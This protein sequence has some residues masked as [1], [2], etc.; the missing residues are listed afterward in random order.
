M[1]FLNPFNYGFLF[2]YMLFAYLI[3]IGEF[4]KNIAKPISLTLLVFSICYGIFYSFDLTLGSQFILIYALLPYSF[5]VAGR[6]LSVD[7]NNLLPLLFVFGI[8]L[9]LPSILSVFQSIFLDG[10]VSLKRDVPNFW[11]GEPEPATN[12][13]GPMVLNMCIPAVLIIR[14]KFLKHN[15][16]TFISLLIFLLSVTCILR[17]GSRT[18]LVISVFAIFFAIIFKMSKQGALKNVI[19]LSFLFLIGNIAIAYV[20]IDGDSDLFSSYADRMESK[21]YGASSA[22]GRTERWAKSIELLFEKPLGWQVE[23]IGHAHNLWFDV[24]RIGGI[25]SFLF[26]LLFSFKIFQK[27]W[28]ISFRKPIDDVKLAGILFIYGIGMNLLFFVEPIMEGYFNCFA[29]FCVLAGIIAE[30]ARI[31]IEKQR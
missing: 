30:L 5:L 15:Y 12:I 22:G 27:T 23:E 29:M 19:F 9:S 31:Q 8:F 1:F 6:C 20:S 26:L 7:K 10:F 4:H 14:W 3:L 18:H 24:A 13:A 25:I 2:G 16:L 21:K 28:V 11:T 17:L